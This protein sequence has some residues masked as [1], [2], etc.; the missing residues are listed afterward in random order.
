MG[1]RLMVA[2]IRDRMAVAAWIQAKSRWSG[3]RRGGRCQRPEPAPA[4]RG[5]VAWAHMLAGGARKGQGRPPVAQ[6][7]CGAHRRGRCLCR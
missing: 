3:G 5:G 4:H 7:R 1:I 6:G 2:W